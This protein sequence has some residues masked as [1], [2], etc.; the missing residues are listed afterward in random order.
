MLYRAQITSGNHHK[1]CFTIASDAVA[2]RV[3][4][5][6]LLESSACNAK[7]PVFEGAIR[8][9]Q[10]CVPEKSCAGLS[11][12]A[13]ACYDAQTGKW[14]ADAVKSFRLSCSSPF[15]FPIYSS[16]AAD[17]SWIRQTIARRDFVDWNGVDC[18]SGF[19][20]CPL[21]KCVDPQQIA[22]GAW[23]QLLS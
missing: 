21:G 20:R 15:P 23:G 7:M 14:S 11:G 10:L 18:P 12:S 13:V 6:E 8:G 9:D 19:F 2:V 17:A 3:Q 4:E 5:S 1:R 22:D 16:V